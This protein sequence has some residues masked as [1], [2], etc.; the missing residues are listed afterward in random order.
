M[1]TGAGANKNGNGHADPAP[2]DQS[3]AVPGNGAPVPA[4]PPTNGKHAAAAAVPPKKDP[5]ATQFKEGNLANPGGVSKAAREARTRLAKTAK[6]TMWVY[7]EKTSR[8]RHAK[9]SERSEAV[10]TEVM[11]YE[12]AANAKDNGRTMAKLLDK[13]YPDATP[14][15]AQVQ[16]SNLVPVSNHNTNDGRRNTA[17]LADPAV[18]KSLMGFINALDDAGGYARDA[19]TGR[20]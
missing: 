15:A 14:I 8:W 9:K 13:V 3:A 2:S 1:D 16:I 10:T 17:E 7:D 19:G 18:R 12:V 6:K 4:V 5:T 20:N 11:Q